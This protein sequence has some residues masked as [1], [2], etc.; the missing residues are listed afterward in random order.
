MT[1]RFLPQFKPFGKVYS[2]ETE[3]HKERLI[4]IEEKN[5][6]NFCIAIILLAAFLLWTAA[7]CVIDVRAIGPQGSAVGFAAINDFVHRLTGVHMSLYTV[8]DWLG[9]VPLAFVL[10]FAI[11]GLVQWI[12]RKRLS[13]VDRS[14]LVLGGFY[15]IV[16]AVYVLFE[17]VAVNY[18]PVL[19]D[20]VLEISYPSSTTMLVMCVMPTAVM[21]LNERI[22]NIVI[23]RGA[24]YII[25]AFV[26]FMVIG[27]LVSGVHWFSD[28]V[29]G[30][31]LSA[32]LLTMYKAIA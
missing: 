7:V 20:G 18:R 29:G 14:I 32:G 26:V 2:G 31:M 4:V 22:K 3:I 25:T 6:R 21:Q 9:L 19:I 13:Q 1:P 30:V 5:R 16:L 15:I 28:I 11:L 10:S 27:R 24:A 17:M 12:M 23:R 8:T